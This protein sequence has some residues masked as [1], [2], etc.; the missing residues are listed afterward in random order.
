MIVVYSAVGHPKRREQA[1]QLAISLDATLHMDWRSEGHH[2]NHW[3]AWNMKPVFSDWGIV[4]EDDAVP[5]RSFDKHVRD[6]LKGLPPDMI[7]SFYSGTSFPTQAQPKYRRAQTTGEPLITNNVYH[8]VGLAIPRHLI[9][10][11][12]AFT[13]TRK[14]PWDEMVGLWAKANK[15]RVKYT[16]PSHVD[17]DDSD[18]VIPPTAW[19][20]RNKPRKAHHFCER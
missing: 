17:H 7:V 18:S 12:L 14:G 15:I 9:D 20:P 6:E 5:C 11:M 3:R 10:D 13:E 8:A 16:Q 2:S 4:L 19:Q 1:E